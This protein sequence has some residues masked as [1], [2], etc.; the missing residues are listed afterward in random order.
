MNRRAAVAIT[1]ATILAVSA[2]AVPATGA[3]G[4]GLVGTETGWRQALAGATLR[5]LPDAG[6]AA[7]A[8]SL[9]SDKASDDS[10]DPDVS[11]VASADPAEWD[12]TGFTVAGGYAPLP[13]RKP[14]TDLTDASV[15]QLAD[16][17][18]LLTYVSSGQT[19]WERYSSAGALIK[20]PHLEIGVLERPMGEK[21]NVGN[22]DAAAVG[23]GVI[24]AQDVC[25]KSGGSDASC[26]SGKWG[27]ALT[28]YDASMRPTGT[29]FVLAGHHDVALAS[30]G[31]RVW[32]VTQSA[33]RVYVTEFSVSDGQAWYQRQY[34]ATNPP[35]PGLKTGYPD[36]ALVGSRLVVAY[37]RGL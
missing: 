5:L 17:S 37:E 19:Y 20:A 22:H 14:M 26:S 32:A 16:G 9:S 28:V 21:L 3:A 12:E 18:L 30:S 15:V 1:L 10:F 27:T 6:P 33:W 25:W 36:V 29:P 4:T 11:L 7:G 2:E 8:T 24:I 35:A 34:A 13:L 31:N 23:S